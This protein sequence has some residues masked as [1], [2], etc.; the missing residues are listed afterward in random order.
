MG[1]PPPPQLSS[2]MALCAPLLPP[3]GAAPGADVGRKPVTE[4][5]AATWAPPQPSAHG[6]QRCFLFFLFLFHFSGALSFPNDEMLKWGMPGSLRASSIC[7]LK[8]H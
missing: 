6:L 3:D 7:F 2:L 1:K 4:G 8:V 5:P